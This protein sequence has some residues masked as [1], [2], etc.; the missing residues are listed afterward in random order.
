MPLW[1]CGG[2]EWLVGFSIH[3][4]PSVV[5]TTCAGELALFGGIIAAQQVTNW[6]LV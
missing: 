6:R 1:N 2:G 4:F 3:S 5:S